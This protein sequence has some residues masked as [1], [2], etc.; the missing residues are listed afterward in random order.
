M[1]LVN[2]VELV[3]QYTCVHSVQCTQLYTAETGRQQL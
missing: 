3:V 2:L 1:L